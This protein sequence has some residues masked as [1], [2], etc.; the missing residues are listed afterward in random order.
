MRVCVWLALRAWQV[1]SELYHRIYIE[2]GALPKQ[3]SEREYEVSAQRACVQG[4]NMLGP[5]RCCR[6]AS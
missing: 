4:S 6:H 2:E 3:I 5:R 1:G